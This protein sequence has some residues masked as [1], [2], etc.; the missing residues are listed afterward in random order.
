MYFFS[1]IVATWTAKFKDEN[2]CE[3]PAAIFSK[4]LELGF[5]LPENSVNKLEYY[6]LQ[7]NW[8]E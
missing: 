6:V 4:Y 1:N 3:D 2:L 8:I 7:H 5:F